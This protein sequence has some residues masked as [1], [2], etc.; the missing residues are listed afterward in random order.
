MALR[1]RIG[2]HPTSLSTPPTRTLAAKCAAGALRIF[3]WRV[4]SAPAVTDKGVVVVYPH[5]SNWDFLIGVLARTVMQLPM[6]W[7][8]KDSLFRFPMR[9]VMLALG[10]TPVDRSRPH[11]LVD[12]LR[13]VMNQHDRYYVTITPE[14]T[15][16]RT[17]HWK[18]GF[19]HLALG[20]NVPVG[21]A[22]IDYKR[23]EV[24]VAEWMPLTGNIEQDLAHIREVYAERRGRYPELMGKI[25]FRDKG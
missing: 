23:R 3:G 18:S 17:D 25:Q 19:Y 7:I 11:G 24:G 14:G 22:F 1:S 16:R 21:L 20:L 2:M 5:T 12:Q 13:E 15:R 10:G 4:V 8:G 6:Y 9:T